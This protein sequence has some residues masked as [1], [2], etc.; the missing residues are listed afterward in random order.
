MDAKH[1]QSVDIVMN[2]IVRPLDDSTAKS[3]LCARIV[4]ELPMWFGRP[5]ANARYIQGVADRDAFAGLVDGVPR[6]LISLEYHF[7]VTCNVW[8]LG[9]TPAHHRRGIGRRLI[10]RAAEEARW[11]GCGQLAVETMSPRADSPEY[12]LSRRFYEALGFLPFVEFEPEPGDYMMW[13][14]R[15]L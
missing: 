2:V 8:W 9:V 5:Q 1:S 6:G 4:K 14:I 3:A 7:A 13:M 12:D 15:T 10:E 11:R